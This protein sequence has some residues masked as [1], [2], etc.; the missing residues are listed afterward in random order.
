M[1]LG[2]SE[3]SKKIQSMLLTVPEGIVIL[4]EGEVNLD[5][6]QIVEGHVEMYTGYGTENEVLIGILGP[7]AL[8]GEFGLLLKQPAIYTIVAFSDVRILRIPN[9]DL[10]DFVAN[11]P[12][13]TV[14]L[15][16]SMAGMME[17][18]QHN[19]SQLSGE[20]EELKD[21]NREVTR[22]NI[23]TRV[24]PEVQKNMLRQYAVG[25]YRSSLLKDAIKR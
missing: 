2:K 11:Y 20:I 18:M 13:S 17:C 8:F 16:Q 5:M 15:L 1:P 7:K 6:Y 4:K 25:S 14:H 12:D 10:G 19:I 22:V 24:M 9:G 3:Y 23:E 21:P